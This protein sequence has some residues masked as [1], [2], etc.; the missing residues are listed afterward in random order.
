M[1]VISGGVGRVVAA[2]PAL[3]GKEYSQDEMEKELKRLL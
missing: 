2:I 3:L 1:S